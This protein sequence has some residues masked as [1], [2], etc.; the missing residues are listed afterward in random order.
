MPRDDRH[1]ENRVIRLVDLITQHEPPVLDRF[2]FVGC[3]INGPAVLLIQGDDTVLA[4]N[5]FDAPNLNALFWEIPPARTLVIGA[6]LASN[7]HFEDC[8]FQG[9]GLAGSM[10]LLDKISSSS[11]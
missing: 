10:V 2:T 3:K 9:V 5:R 7:C 4:G 11:K 1:Y 8:Q 6:I